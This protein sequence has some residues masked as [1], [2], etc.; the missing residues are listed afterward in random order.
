MKTLVLVLCG[1]TAAASQLTAADSAESNASPSSR[2]PSVAGARDGAPHS[3]LPALD[4]TGAKAPQVSVLI[5][6]LDSALAHDM[7]TSGFL[8]ETGQQAPVEEFNTVVL[9]GPPAGGA[10][11]IL[12]Y[13]KEGG[14]L[15]ITGTIMSQDAER[16][17][18]N[19]FLKP[20]GV[21]YAR[22][23]VV[24]PRDG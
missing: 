18:W 22:E 5:P 7:E 1:W 24:D 8:V 12:S 2:A 17:A 3:H 13:V 11:K 4:V 21:E 19:A 10:D 14:G 15:L 16:A 20:L 9:Y 6:I 23:V